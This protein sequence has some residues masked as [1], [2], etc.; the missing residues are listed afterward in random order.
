MIFHGKVQPEEAVAVLV[1]VCTFQGTGYSGA[2]DNDNDNSTE[3]GYNRK[4][5]S[6]FWKRLERMRTL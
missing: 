6:C 4:Q 5:V 3:I 1:S 2:N